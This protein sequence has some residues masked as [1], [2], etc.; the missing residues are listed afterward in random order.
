MLSTKA[1]L[2]FGYIILICVLLGAIGYI[3]KQMLLLTEST[4]LEES[5]YSRRRTTHNI[6]SGLYETEVISQAL[7][8]GSNIEY[9]HY[10]QAMK[11][12]YM[13]IDTL[14]MQLTDTL[15]QARLDTVRSLL[16]DKSRNMLA[17]LKAM[18]L[19]PTDMI[20]RQQLDSLLMEHD[21]LI[22][23][24]H[25]RRRVV[26]HHNSY[27]IRHEP[28]SFLKRVA[29]V[30]SP[31]KA[32]STEVSNIIQEEFTDT[33][34]EA[35]SPIDTLASM[36]SGIQHK[37]FQT[38][39]DEM[40]NLD[41][42]INR[43]K[44]AGSKLSQRV[45]QLLESIEKDEQE[46][47]QKKMLQ[48][49]VIRSQ[50][51]KTIGA[52]SVL[53]VILMLIFFWIIW[54]DITR[55]NHY[56][57]ELEKAKNYAEDLLAARE[58]LMLTITHDIKAP[59]GSI[60]GYTDLLE[61]LIT[62]KRQ[63]FYLSGMKNSAKHLLA[64]VTSLLDFHRLEA[65]KMDLNNVAFKPYRL[66]EDICNS[67]LPLAHEKGLNLEFCPKIDNNLTLEGDPFRIRQIVENLLSNA[68][69]F[70]HKGSIIVKTEYQGNQ[71]TLSVT[72]TGQGM[73][74]SEQEKIFKAFTRL[75]GAQG[76][77]GFGLGL[78]ITRKL[79]EL[80]NGK[81]NV[82]SMPGKGS[83][84]HVSLP[85]PSYRIPPSDSD[86]EQNITE[87][88]RDVNTDILPPIRF[89]IIDDDMIQMQL[90]EAMILSLYPSI[91][92]NRL[93]I[94]CSDNPEEVFRLVQEEKPDI[95]FT[96][97]QMPVMNGF[98][99][100]R[101]IRSLSSEHAKNVPVIAITARGELTEKDFTAHGFA[102]MLNKPF[103]RIDLEKVIRKVLDLENTCYIVHNDEFST[104]KTDKYEQNEFR[105][106]ALTAFSMDDDDA[107]KEIILTF[108]SE[109]QKNLESLKNAVENKNM[110]TL[111][112]IAHK[113][114]P[115]FSMLQADSA[116]PA[117]KHLDSSRGETHYSDEAE[118]YA[119]I[120]IKTATKAIKY[121]E[122][123]ELNK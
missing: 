83:T 89:L 82:E 58:Q 21:S 4:G 113:M 65:G 20:Y 104:N 12:V 45:N 112:S 74:L 14:Q 100:L 72:D 80:L 56:R 115:T 102:T 99:L 103:N 95:I 3:Y 36:L 97:I 106:S 79:T 61:R 109:T 51:A 92:D 8:S 5:I 11:K 76:Q 66:L 93:Y 122:K 49:Q 28:K 96:D 16:R 75:P 81:I 114:L 24:S 63:K 116:L 47:S 107:A 22:N 7:R 43:L 1:K 85:L 73:T 69:K 10:S 34:D 9:I 39:Q 50:A 78:S 110:A 62:D 41:Y 46:A 38:R 53:A 19:T 88:V 55:S 121:A 101:N 60:I 40:K 13:S 30:F 98:D 35:F 32:D 15:Q 17:V 42:K 91:P 44:I 87:N 2:A 29:D 84:F 67:F 23:T 26:T 68:L 64:L 90:T 57:R 108:I 120:I 54:R 48:E 119:L 111:C 105:F 25:V 94:K 70:T 27:V 77:E 118:E 18:E 71:F 117:L 33:I 123:L 52:I 86:K 37:V 59:A 31:G 6:I